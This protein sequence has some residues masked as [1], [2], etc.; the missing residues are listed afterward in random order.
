MK[1]G[2]ENQYMAYREAQIWLI[3]DFS[4]EYTGAKRH[5]KYVSRYKWL[6]LFSS[7]NVSLKQVKH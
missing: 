6:A 4:S 7:R 5:A 1:A 2:K 3:T